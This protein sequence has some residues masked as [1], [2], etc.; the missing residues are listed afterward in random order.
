ME[1]FQNPSE[2]EQYKRRL[3]FD[4]AGV[5]QN[6]KIWCFWND[7]WEGSLILDTVQQVTIQFKKNEKDFLISAV[8]ARCNA[9]ERLELW[10]ELE[11][12]AENVR[13]P[14]VIGGDFNVILNEKEKLGGLEFTINEAIDFD[15]LISSNALSEVQF[16]GSKYTWWNGRIEEAC[17][18]KRL[19]RILVNHEFLEVFP[20]SEVQHLIRQGSDHAPLHMSCNTDEVPINKPFRFMNFWSKHQQFKKIVEDSWK[21]DFAGNPFLELHAKM[22]NVK[23]ALSTWSR[24]V[25]GNVFQQIATLE[26]IIKVREAQ[27]QIHPSADNRAALNKVE[28]DLKKYL[29][30]EKEF[31]RQKSGMKWFKEGDM[32]TKFF[33]SEIGNAAV[34]YFWDQFTEENRVEDYTMIDHIP[35]CITAEENEEMTKLPDQEE[36]YRVVSALNGSSACGPDG[37]TGYFF[38][39][40]WEIIGEDITKVVKAFFCGQEL[41][42]FITHTNLVL[43]P[44][45]ESV[46]SFTD[47]RPI[48]LSSF[49]NKVISRMVHERMILVLPNI[50]SQNQAGFVK[51]RSITENIL[52]AQEIIRDINRRNNNVNVV[53]KLDMAKAYD[54]V[55]WIF[56]T[57][58]LRKFGFAEV[59]IDMVWRIISNNWYSVLVNGITHGFFQSSR[60]LKQGDPLSPTLFII[61]AEVLS[62]GLNNLHRDESMKGYGLPKWSPEINHL[63]YADDTILFGSGDRGSIIKMMR[64]LREYELV[65]GQKVNKSKSFFYLHDNTPL[66]VA[67]RMRSV[68]AFSF[69]PTQKGVRSNSSYFRQVFLGY[70]GGIKGKHWVAWG[71]LC[72]PKA[73]GGLG[74]RSLHDVNK[75]LFAKLWWNFRVSTTSLWAKFMWNKYCKKLHPVVVTSLGASQVWKKMIIVREEVEH[76]IWWQIKAGNSSFWFDNWTRQGALYYTE[77][78]LAQEEE[79]EV[80]DF[81]INGMWDEGKLRNLVSEEMVEHIILNIRPKTLETV[82]DK[83]WWSGNSTGLFTVKSTYHRVRGRKAKEEW[84]RYMWIKGMPIKISFFLWRVWRRKIAI[85]DNLKKMKIPVVSKCYCCKKGEME[86][87]THL[88]LTAPIAQKLWKQFASCAEDP[89]W[90][91][92]RSKSLHAPAL[93]ENQTSTKRKSKKEV[94]ESSKAKDAKTQKKRGRK[95]APPISR[96][97]LPMMAILYFIHTFV[98]SQLDDAPIPIEDFL[99]VEDGNYQQFSWGQLAFTKLMK[100]FRKEYKPYKQV[101]R[102]NGFPYALN[103]WVNECASIIHNEIAIKEGNGIP[104]VCNWKVVGAKPKFEMFME[105]IFTENDCS[106]VQPTQEE[107][108]SLDLPN[109]SHVPPTQPATSNVNHKE[110]QPDEV[111]GFEE[112]SS[113]PLE[114][115]LRRSTRVSTTGFTLPPREERTILD[116]AGLEELKGHMKSYDNGGISMPHIVDDSVDKDNVNPQSASDQFFQQIIS[117][118]Q[119]NFATVDHDVDA[120]VVEVEKRHVIEENIAKDSTTSA[121]ISS[122]T[123]AVIDA[124]VYKLPNES[125]NVAP[126]SVII[127][128]QLTD[129]DDFL[130]DSQLPTQLPVKESAHNLDTK[131]P[132]PRNRMPSKISQSPYVNTFGSSDKGKGKIDDDIRSYTPFEGCGIT[133]Q[134][135]S[136]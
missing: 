27:L 57:K 115:L 38:Q 1:P 11:S 72:F 55:S 51:G 10:E 52:L 94:R 124:I 68:Y 116:N 43:L 20:A 66:M 106:N 99:M 60:G 103:I 114:Q 135:S 28:A 45:K 130:F 7:D 125:I 102:L 24:E 77:G 85:D 75:A 48:S 34:E 132:T 117:P 87:M 40:C 89:N 96:S 104:R 22:K 23:K 131:T 136:V 83:A 50:I 120:S 73:E 100:S 110:V 53:V 58:V 91:K 118:I 134:V 71:D 105:N 44:K 111:P 97:T 25:F 33:H 65:S 5:N 121:S 82:I 80:K 2:L 81:I 64:I 41:P 31:W 67:I 56:L 15:S 47:L 62:R 35:K 93:M 12:I 79:L 26:D 133:Y 4:K 16:S 19:D 3:G 98:F 128:L 32:N 8:Y 46:K 108:R 101:Y 9:M 14:W 109:N 123:E 36:V 92:Q 113:K 54:R 70:M 127:P 84:R 49:I 30:L 126:L 59:I 122:G 29:R 37:F 86:T 107:I 63:S 42:K 119:M 74:F 95:V 129:S 17:I 18:F 6:G 39:Y 76:D 78:N 90:A 21:I 13:C 69:K 112:F 61:A 88:L